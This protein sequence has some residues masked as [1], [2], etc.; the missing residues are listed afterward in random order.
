M[1]TTSDL[2]QRL[3]PTLPEHTWLARLVEVAPGVR[4]TQIFAVTAGL[5]NLLGFHWPD[6]LVGAYMSHLHLP[7]EPTVCANMRPYGCARCRS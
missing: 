1:V 5:E 3:L 2:L 7:D 4:D 6:T